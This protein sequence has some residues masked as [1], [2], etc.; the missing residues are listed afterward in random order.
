M[1]EQG[2]VFG[3]STEMSGGGDFTPIVKYDSRA[4]RIFR[5]DRV[6][7]NDGFVSDPVDITQGF[8]AVFDFEN[9]EVG[10]ID[11]PVA[12]LHRR[13]P[14]SCSAPRCSIGLPAKSTRTG[15]AF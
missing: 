12:C 8:K 7:T 3:F 1:V 15:C 5:V 13:S 4:G 10:W 9:I 11:F 2:N 6:Q 14:L